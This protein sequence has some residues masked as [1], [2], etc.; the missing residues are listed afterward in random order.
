MYAVGQNKI[1]VKMIST[2]SV[3]WFSISNPLLFMICD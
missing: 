3:V 2:Y 1:Q